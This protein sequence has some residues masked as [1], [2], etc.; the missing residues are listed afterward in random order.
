[1]SLIKYGKNEPV[2]DTFQAFLVT[3]AKFTATEEYPIIPLE[4]VSKI[5]PTKI[6]PFSKA[7][8][9]RGDLSDTFI[10]TFE[11]DSS[12]ERIRKNPKKYLEFFKRTAGL[13]GFD[14]SVHTDMPLI[15]QKSQINDNLSL[16]YYFGVNGIPVI[17]NIRCG[18]DELLPEFITAIP[19]H[20]LIAIGVH[21]FCKYK[22]EKYEWFC[23]LEKILRELEPTGIIVYG[24]LSDHIFDTFKEKYNF[25][26]YT[27]WIYT[28]GKEVTKYGN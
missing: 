26:F 22:F 1:M 17:P 21:G 13:I 10:C 14:Y 12:F 23:F 20:T 6:M 9:Y 19:K 27:P 16:T 2:N 4:T 18:V 7:I 11:A 8:N 15:K 5:T 28:H 24:S 25:Y 3:N